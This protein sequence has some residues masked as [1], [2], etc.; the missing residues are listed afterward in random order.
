MYSIFLL[1]QTENDLDNIIEYL[2]ENSS[3]KTASNFLDD[4]YEK[5]EIIKKTPFIYATAYQYPKYRR[6]LVGKIA[7][8]YHVLEEENKIEIVAVF[9]SS[10]NIPNLLE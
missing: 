8:F 10:R 4:F 2:A 9:H 5:V 7:A 1:P 3:G 6:F